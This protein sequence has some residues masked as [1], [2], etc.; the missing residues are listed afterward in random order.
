[1]PHYHWRSTQQPLLPSDDNTGDWW[2]FYCTRWKRGMFGSV[3]NHPR[4]SVLVFC[5]FVG[6]ITWW[7]PSIVRLQ[8]SAVGSEVTLSEVLSAGAV[9]VVTVDEMLWVSHEFSLRLEIRSWP[10]QGLVKILRQ[11][12]PVKWDS[13]PHLRPAAFSPTVTSTYSQLALWHPYP[14][15]FHLKL[16]SSCPWIILSWDRVL[17]YPGQNYPKGDT[18][19]RN[20]AGSHFWG[21][22]GIHKYLF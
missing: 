12:E 1:M 9:A 13:A 4:M 6:M 2:L 21:W 20:E 10:P 17:E 7:Q 22:G 11:R 19:R 16:E 5:L 14:R 8:H 3:N 15:A 18:E